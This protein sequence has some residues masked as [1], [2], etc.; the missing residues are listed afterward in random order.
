MGAVLL[1][2]TGEPRSHCWPR[3]FVW[4][5]RQLH[6][7]AGSISWSCTCPAGRSP[8]HAFRYDFA[9]SIRVFAFH[10]LLIGGLIFRSTYMPKWLGALLVI[11]GGAWLVNDLKPYLYPTANLGFLEPLFWIELIFMLWLLIGGWKIPEP[12]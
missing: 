12:A 4:C 1:A 2:G 10:L 3:F 7:P 8:T 6:S 11:D 5:I 9:A